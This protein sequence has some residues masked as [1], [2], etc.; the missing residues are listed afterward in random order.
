M[1]KISVLGPKGTYSDIACK[2]Y[3]AIN[4]MNDYEIAY[5]KTILQTCIA[6][7]DLRLVPFENTLDGFVMESLDTIINNN[8]HI[9]DEIK[10]PIDFSFVTNEKS[11]DDVKEVYVQ[12]KAKG[13]CINFL[14][15][16]N[17]INTESNG[18]SLELIRNN[19][20][21]GFGAIVIPDEIG[22]NEFKL[23]IDHV[24]DIK[25]NETRFV[26]LTNDD[27]KRIDNNFLASIVVTSLVDRP[28]ILYD[29]LTVFHDLNI[30]MNSIL[31]RPLKTSMGQYK[32]YI[33]CSFKDN[34]YVLLNDLLNKLRLNFKVDLIGTYKGC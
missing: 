3:L 26:I 24:T 2:K 11:I 32:F 17:T 4:N 1:K 5:Y 9:I 20:Q 15:N 25:N 19:K 18:Q 33:E 28:G 14:N 13:Q 22:E 16:F 30:N 31:S 6:K 23:K 34:G 7:D 10:L 21:K 29:I 27:V 8:Y 12:F